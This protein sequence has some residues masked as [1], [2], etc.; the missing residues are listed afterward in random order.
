LAVFARREGC[1]AARIAP[2]IMLTG[3]LLGAP[4]PR[5]QAT[6]TTMRDLF[7]GERLSFTGTLVRASG[8]S[9]IV[10]YAITCCRADASPI[11]VRLERSPPD[12]NGAWLRVDGVVEDRDGAMQLQAHRIQ[13]ISPPNDPF[14]YW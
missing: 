8:T 9:A 4:P 3:A 12:E 14:I 10:R 1:T 2:A 11:A 5:Y 7:A 13:R 6:E